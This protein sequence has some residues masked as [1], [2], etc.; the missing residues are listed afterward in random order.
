MIPDSDYARRQLALRLNIL[1]INMGQ[2]GSH[3]E[4][5]LEAGEVLEALRPQ[6]RR[7]RRLESRVQSL[8][9]SLTPS[10]AAPEEAEDVDLRDEL[11]AIRRAISRVRKKAARVEKRHYRSGMTN[12]VDIIESGLGVLEGA[13][14]Y[15]C[16]LRRRHET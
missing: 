9:Q 4:E 8:L 1:E 6:Q 11:V 7:L 10:A 16:S 3:V 14:A 15:S 12:A 2:L 13:T 5:L